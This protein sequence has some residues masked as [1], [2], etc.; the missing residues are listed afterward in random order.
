MKSNVM[1]GDR[2][3]ALTLPKMPNS[4]IQRNSIKISHRKMNGM[5]ITNGIKYT[6][7]VKAAKPPT[8]SA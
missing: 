5:R 8:T 2:T 7:A 1:E 4:T 3:E 6:T